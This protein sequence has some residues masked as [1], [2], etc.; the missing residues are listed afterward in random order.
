MQEEI[1]KTYPDLLLHY[2]NYTRSVDLLRYNSVTNIKR[3]W[4]HRKRAVEI[5]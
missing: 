2:F 3:D 5:R 1:P 4:K